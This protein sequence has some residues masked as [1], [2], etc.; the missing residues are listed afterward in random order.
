MVAVMSSGAVLLVAACSNSTPTVLPDPTHTPPAGVATPT[1]V[2]GPATPTA[3]TIPSPQPTTVPTPTSGSSDIP[4]PTPQMP[5]ASTPTPTPFPS[6]TPT[7][8]PGADG[9]AIS[10][11]P[12]LERFNVPADPQPV[13]PPVPE[14]PFPTPPPAPA[15]NVNLTPHSVGNGFGL[16]LSGADG[17][18]VFDPESIEISWWV[19]NVGPLATSEQFNIEVRFDGVVLAQ[20]TAQGLA[21]DAFIFIEDRPGLFAGVPVSPGMHTVELVIDPLN[22]INETN[23]LDNVVVNEVMMSGTTVTELPT[24]LL[25]NLIPAPF[26]GKLEPLFVSS[27]EGDPLSGKLSVDAPTYLALGAANRSIQYVEGQVEVDLYFD[28]LLVRRL[29]WDDVPAIGSLRFESED[30][31]DLIDISAGPHMLRVLVDPLNRIQESDETDNEYEIELVWGTGTPPPAEE[32]FQLKTPE[33]EP[34]THANLM[35]YRPFGWDAA[36]TAAPIPAS[37]PQGKDGWLN[38][39]QAARINFSFTNASRFSISLTDQ[40]KA[41]VLL[42]GQLMQRIQFHSGSSNEGSRWSDDVILMIGEVPPGEHTV[43]IVLDP[44]GLIDE[45]SEADNVYERTFT[46]H[47]GRDPGLDEPFSMS[48]EEIQDA[49]EPLFGEMRREV[50]PAFN[51]DGRDWTG[52]I[53]AAGRAAYYLLTGRDVHE[54]GYVIHFLPPEQFDENS[55]ATCMSSWITMTESEY[56]ERF[57]RCTTGRGEVGFKTRSNGQIHIFVDL[58][59]SPLDALGTYLHELGHGLQDLI[60]PAQTELRPSSGSRGLFEAQAQIFEAAGWRAIEEFMEESLS[61]FPDVESAR[62][63]FEFLFDLRRNRGTEHDIG[64]RLLWSQALSAGAGTEFSGELRSNGKLSSES[65]YEM[66]NFLVTI[67]ALNVETWAIETLSRTSLMTE[68]QQI[69]S[70]RFVQGLGNE[71]TGHPALQD[72]TWLAP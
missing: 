44:E 57:E 52:E 16:T 39:S 32:P 30:I 54:E 66:F 18:G 13:P 61:L 5:A 1:Q 15:G 58:G 47:E 27:H 10:A 26:E 28:D 7:P 45:L 70:Q 29:T 8:H 51:P 48:G 23:E 55:V 24:E 36:I 34:T 41:D 25:P 63:R 72:S 62:E 64:Y 21:R 17:S 14:G 33:R 71:E 2:T 56:E 38:S 42:D 22:Q 35:P 4:S 3:G 43:R 9:E 31:R 6:P 11:F 59:L 40:L 69:A 50:G 19:A 60:N 12:V 65:A 67:A 46:W 20:W 53:V 68:F 49:L 37:G